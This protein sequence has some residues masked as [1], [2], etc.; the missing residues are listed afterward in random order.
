MNEISSASRVYVDSNIFIYL[1]ESESGLFDKTKAF[2]THVDAVGARVVTNE[3]TVAECVYRPGRDGN[4][5]LV[6][7]YETLF[8]KDGEVEMAPL[9]GPLAKRAALFGGAMGLKLIDAI[10]YMSALEAGCDFFVTADTAFKSGPEM[11]VMRV[12]E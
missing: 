5:P 8:E 4:F 6:S 3:I 7:K 11:T 2:F 10:H 9:D 12:A 1:L